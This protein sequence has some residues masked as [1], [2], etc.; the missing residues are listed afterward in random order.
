M[1][2]NILILFLFSI[3]ISPATFSQRRVLTP[4]EAENLREKVQEACRNT[5][6]IESDFT[7][8]K[9]MSLLSEKITSSGKFFFKKE[10]MLRWEYTAPYPYLIIINNDIMYVIDDDKENKVNLQSNRVFREINNIILG[11]VQGTL[12]ND[13]KN[14]KA[15]LFDTRSLYLATL[16]PQSPKLKETLNEID[17]FFNK[18]DNTVEQLIMREASG[19]YT[20]IEFHSKKLNQPIADEKFLPR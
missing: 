1:Y 16:F 3:L 6:S 11:A 13:P 4:K 9:E 2:K 18:T 14:F 15:T 10:K 8:E 20:R 19:D 17:L 5:I 12:L 7:Q